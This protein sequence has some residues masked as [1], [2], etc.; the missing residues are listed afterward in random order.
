MKKY[1][2]KALLYQS[3]YSGRWGLLGGSI[4]LSIIVYSSL[5]SNFELVKYRISNLDANIMDVWDLYLNL[6]VCILIFAIYILITGLNKRNNLTFVTSGPFTREEVKRNEMIFLFGSLFL[7]AIVCLYVSICSFISNSEIL[8]FIYGAWR[9]LALSFIRLI[10]IGSGFILYLTLFDMLFSNTIVTILSLV[11]FPILIIY[12]LLGIRNICYALFQ[13]DIFPYYIV[14][15]IV[16]FMQPALNFFTKRY[17]AINFDIKRVMLP[18]ILIIMFMILTYLFIK[19]I[20]KKITIN[21]IN[22][23]FIFPV[24]ESIYIGMICFSVISF[25]VS[26]LIDKLFF[27]TNIYNGKPVISLNYIMSIISVILIISVM[28]TASYYLQKII[29]RKIHKLF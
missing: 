9:E 20:N 26:V 4:I 14:S 8:P 25:V 5:N 19:F 3:Y 2:N 24:V 1:I 28:A 15:S 7:F 12:N 29:K 18:V 23:F 10:I 22:K 21:N 11:A 6:F 17:N 16:H 27:Y 13:K